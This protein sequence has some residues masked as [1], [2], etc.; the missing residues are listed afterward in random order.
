VSRN[1]VVDTGNTGIEVEACASCVVE[2]NVVVQR[3]GGFGTRGVV[4]GDRTH[5][6][7]DE[8][9]PLDAAR[10]RNN[11]VVFAGAATGSNIGVAVGV[12]GAGHVVSG[13]AV[14]ATAGSLTCF[15]RNLA[16]SAYRADHN[17]CFGEGS[18]VWD[19]RRGSLADT[20]AAG[21]DAHSLER[22]P[23]FGRAALERLDFT[24]A[25]GSPLV[26]A[27]DPADGA[28]NDFAGLKRPSPPDIGA[29]QHAPSR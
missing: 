22:A 28:P 8:D 3:Q 9:A 10:V 17:L 13:N 11:T 24:P 18:P 26:G 2:N 14:W 15:D 25:A 1:L 27:G 21:L 23:G 29:F 4:V 5:R 6:R 16:P 7:G 19:D 20:K 12:E